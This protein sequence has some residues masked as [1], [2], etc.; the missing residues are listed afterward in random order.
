MLV[1]WHQAELRGIL[2][3]LTAIEVMCFT[4]NGRVLQH[5][6]AIS[7]SSVHCTIGVDLNSVLMSNILSLS[8]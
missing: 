5:D 7:F 4:D 6:I 3:S 1:V 8:F 2:Y